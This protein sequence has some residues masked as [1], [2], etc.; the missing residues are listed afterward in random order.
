LII[1]VG[2]LSPDEFRQLIQL[3]V[4]SSV[5]RDILDRPP[6]ALS[7]REERWIK[8]SLLVVSFAKWPS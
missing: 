8:P 4:L 1:S 2:Q 7:I 5:P 3:A 6:L